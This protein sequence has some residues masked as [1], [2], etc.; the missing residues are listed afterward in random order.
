MAIYICLLWVGSSSLVLFVAVTVA[1]L[2][3]AVMA[4]R[5]IQRN[6]SLRGRAWAILGLTGGIV[7]IG[8]LVLAL[9]FLVTV[10]LAR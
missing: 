7:G 10:L 4:L 8:L 1:A 2:V 9:Y 6:Q 5:R 3:S